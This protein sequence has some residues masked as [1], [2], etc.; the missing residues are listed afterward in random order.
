[1]LAK[2]HAV[3]FFFVPDNQQNMHERLCNWSLYVAVK[4]PHWVSPMWRQGR[5][6]G[7]QW[8]VPELKPTVDTLDG[9]KIEKAVGALPEAHRQALRWSYCYK[10]N[11]RIPRRELGVTD[12]GLIRLIADGRRM[13]INRAV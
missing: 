11:P 4:R 9:H 12:E 2:V 3:D 1:M 7:R 5:S 10:T 13:L 6:G 8:H